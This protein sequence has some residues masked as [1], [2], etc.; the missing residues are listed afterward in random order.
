M[1]LSIVVPVYN[2]ERYV[3][4][5]ILSIINQD[6]EL[7]NDIEVIIVND[8]TKDQSVERIIDLVDKYTNISLVNQDNLSLSVARNNGLSL[9]KGEYVWFVD[10]DDWISADAVKKLLPHLNNNNDIISF[11]FTQVT[12]VEETLCSIYFD[13]VTTLSGIETFRRG[14]EFST[15][16]QRAVY[17]KSFLE[18]NNLTF[19]PGVYNQD[20]ELCLRASYLAKTVT[21]LPFSIY[22]FLRTSGDKHKSIMNTVKPKLGYDYLTVSKSLLEFAR[23]NVH[24]ND[25]FTLFEKHIAVLIN[26]GINVISKCSKDDQRRFLNMYR[27]FKTLNKCY[28]NAG[29]KYF[30]EGLLFSLFPNKIISIFKM[31]QLFKG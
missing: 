8:G 1:K 3:R 25:V 22:F 17:K 21:L 27:E 24:E 29:G 18:N 4:K 30:V 13:E 5:C 2:V 10:S 20:D 11:G 26:C 12:E 7:F 15:M 28:L 19:M 14:C 6:D 31:L 16:A 23:Q 9:A